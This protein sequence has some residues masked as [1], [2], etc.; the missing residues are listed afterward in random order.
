[1]KVDTEMRD[2]MKNFIQDMPVG[3]CV[4]LLNFAILL[5]RAAED[6]YEINGRSAATVDEATD[7]L[8]AEWEKETDA[9]EGD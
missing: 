4:P 7:M 1:M 8:A 6:R 3:L 2:D 9:D 5:K